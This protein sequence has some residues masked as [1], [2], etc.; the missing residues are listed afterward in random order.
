MKINLGFSTCPNDTFMFD[1]LVHGKVNTQDFSFST[2]MED[3]LHLNHRAI[4]QEPDMIKIS[5]NAYGQVAEH[6]RLLRSGS[7]MGKGCG[8][9]LIAREPVSIA[10]LI[11]RNA[12]IAIPGQN[13]TANLLLHFFAPQLTNRV[14]MLFHEVMPAVLEGRAE[15]G[16]IIHENRFTYGNFGLVCLQDLG[17]YWESQTGLPIPLGAIAAK[18]SLGEERIGLLENMLRDSVAFAFANPTDSSGFV[19]E[20]AQ[21]LSEEVT[22]A[23]INLYVNEYSLDF[24]P[25]G[26]EAIRKLLQVGSEMGLYPEGPILQGILNG[27]LRPGQ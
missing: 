1:A 5:Y 25:E 26:E 24:G 14:E 3:I 19:R 10:D 21:E 17:E 18:R 7:A 27:I 16:L 8:P 6:Y 15:A 11:A 12:T 22:Q 20:H 13:T 23:H 2:V 4:A 9:L